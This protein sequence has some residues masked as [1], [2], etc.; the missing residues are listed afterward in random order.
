MTELNITQQPLAIT[1]TGM[2]TGVG[3]DT[4]ST[5]AAVRASIDNFQETRFIDAGGEWIQACEVPLE[6]PWS[7]TRKLAK[8]LAQ[9]LIECAQQGKVD[10]EQV[11]LIICLAEKERP[12]RVENL[13]N[14]VFFE[15]QEEL[16]IRF[17]KDSK[18]VEHGRVG[19][20]VAMR[21]AREMIYKEKAEHIIVAG[22]DSLITGPA[23]RVYEE[24]DRVLTSQNSDGF[25]PGE[26]AAAVLVTAPK[27]SDEKQLICMGLGFGVEKSTIDSEEPLR[28]DGLTTAIKESLNDANCNE[29]ILDFKITDTSG[30]Q[31]Y[32][33]EA[34]LAFSRVDRTK[35][36]E[37]DFWH[38]S[39]CV[40]E[41]GAAMGMVMV[42]V[43]KSACEKSYSKGNH[44]LA[45]L[46]SDDG[47]R[48]SMVLFWQM[49][50][51]K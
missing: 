21:Q 41:V 39:D 50:G 30:E 6:Q 45:H 14:R 11:P 2:V 31:Y 22:V 19:G 51:R 8:M 48:S 36:T 4:K 37:F 38:P 26:A 28:A 43:L 46:G 42:I 29:S 23:L 27:A 47:K 9:A 17:H 12:G 1:A 10:L 20:L 40:G 32:F 44:V 18:V 33:K 5:C 16:G 3:L 7:G 13:S 35:R 15:T 24:Q 25:I 49:V 34:S